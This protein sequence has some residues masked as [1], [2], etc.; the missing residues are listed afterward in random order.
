[1]FQDVNNF[2]QSSNNEAEIHNVVIEIVS[3][4]FFFYRC[5]AGFSGATCATEGTTFGKSHNFFVLI[6]YLI[7]SVQL[8][9]NSTFGCF[10]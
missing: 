10:A 2:E 1:M 5:L 7:G 9:C 3:I 8:D 4:N 6:V